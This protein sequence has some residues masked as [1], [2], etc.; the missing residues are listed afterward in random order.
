[1]ALLE[2]GFPQIS[3]LGAMRLLRVLQAFRKTVVMRTLLES[4]WGLSSI[5]VLLAF[6]FMIFAIMGVNI[7]KGAIH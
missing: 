5:L 7:W 1:M 2:L 4:I 6:S 3:K